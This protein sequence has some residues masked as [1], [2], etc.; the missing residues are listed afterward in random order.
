MSRVTPDEDFDSSLEDWI[1]GNKPLEPAPGASDPL[2]ALFVAA[3]R[4]A[5]QLSDEEAAQVF[6]SVRRRST[7]RANRLILPWIAA[8]AV[9]LGVVASWRTRGPA[10]A[11]TI[12]DQVSFEAV[13]QGT[14]V[15]LEMTVY[16][17][18]EEREER[19]VKKAL[20]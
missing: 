13:N 9:T 20:P 11:R 7:T 2:V 8:A 18:G 14:V 5:P 19:D 10:P 15:L 6:A 4:A 16:R 3:R 1:E 17:I 12:V